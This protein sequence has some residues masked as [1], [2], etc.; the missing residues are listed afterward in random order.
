M[1]KYLIL[2]LAALAMLSGC[3][4][5]N[6]GD[7]TTFTAT[8]EQSGA[9]TTLGSGDNAGKVFW[10]LND[11]ISINGVAYTAT[12]VGSS[13]AT[14]AT[15]T[16]IEATGAAGSTYYAYYPASLYSDG[17][18]V[19]PRVQDYVDGTIRNLPMYAES[20]DH[21]LVF[22]NL[23][24]VLAITVPDSVMTTVDSITVYS[25]QQMN[26]A[27][28]VSYSNDVPSVT[29][30]TSATDYAHKTVVLSMGG[31]P[32][33]I[34]DDGKTFYIA[35][36]AQTYGSLAIIVAGSKTVTNGT[37]TAKIKESTSSSMNV[38]RSKIYPI[39][40][41]GTTPIRGTAAVSTSANRPNN[42][43]EWVRLWKNGPCFAAFNVGATIT[44]YASPVTGNG[45]DV[46]TT[47]VQPYITENVGGLYFWG[48]SN[49]ENK[50]VSNSRT[51]DYT[52]GSGNLGTS[53][54]MA[55]Q[56]WGS[57]WK[58]PSQA[59]LNALINTTNCTETDYYST[60]YYLGVTT[61]GFH[62]NVYTGNGAY[63][64]NHIFLPASGKFS[65]SG[66][67]T[68]SYTIQSEGGFGSYWSLTKYNNNNNSQAYYLNFS[69][70]DQIVKGNYR[71][72]GF[73][74]R[75]VLAN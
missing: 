64:Y 63:A 6:N 40:F 37:V 65:G 55:R 67:S 32:V 62:G 8:I 43:C 53:N 28:S 49:F 24:G 45:S 44:N 47:I 72:Y 22:K 51:S 15:F 27:I 5:D 12:T 30:S 66:T 10:E 48:G 50:R 35:V 71:Y 36:P 38:Q 2:S 73:S 16:A 33:T 46:T 3:K 60:N 68:S 54:D 57:N 13:N 74:V 18:C 52:T 41:S 17:G 61:N 58:V 56:L 75:A 20:T 34:P 59:N 39:T 21:N 25:D 31:S 69:N 26:G 1:K 70:N 11:A 9:K 7:V 19:L 23:C 14:Q 4:K 29:F 42:T